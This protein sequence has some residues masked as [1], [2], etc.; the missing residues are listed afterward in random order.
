VHGTSFRNPS[1]SKSRGVA[2]VH[3]QAERAR[4]G[5]VKPRTFRTYEQGGLLG[6]CPN[7]SSSTK[8]RRVA[9][10][11]PQFLITGSQALARARGSIDHQAQHHLAGPFVPL[12]VARATETCSR[13][14]LFGHVRGALREQPATEGF[15]KKPREEHFFWMRWRE[16]VGDAGQAVGA[17]QEGEVRGSVRSRDTCR[18]PCH[19]SLPIVIEHEVKGGTSGRIFYRLSVVTLRCHR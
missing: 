5:S 18:W 11:D 9:Q 15:W 4:R 19:S 8:D 6:R 16:T 12:T 7:N 14:E 17:L 2:R 13:P 3:R 1:K 10:P